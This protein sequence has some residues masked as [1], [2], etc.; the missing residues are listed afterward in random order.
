VLG[1]WEGS[2]L[3]QLLTSLLL[4]GGFGVRIGDLRQ[5]RYSTGTWALLPLL[6]LEDR[7][8]FAALGRRPQKSGSESAMCAVPT[9]LVPVS[10]SR[11]SPS[12]SCFGPAC[13]VRVPSCGPA[14]TFRPSWYGWNLEFSSTRSR[15]SCESPNELSVRCCRCRL[16]SVMC[17]VCSGCSG[18]EIRL[19]VR[20][21][22]VD[23]EGREVGTWSVSP[24]RNER[25]ETCVQ[26]CAVDS[27]GPIRWWPW[28]HMPLNRLHA[29]AD[30]LADVDPPSRGR[31][32]RG[33]LTLVPGWRTWTA[34]GLFSAIRFRRSLLRGSSSR[35]VFFSANKA[36]QKK[37][38][39]CVYTSISKSFKT[40]IQ[41]LASQSPT[42]TCA[43]TAGRPRVSS[44]DLVSGPIVT[45]SSVEHVGSSSS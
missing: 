33:C 39:F 16:M 44:L 42:L 22:R 21:G 12:G 13:S 28:W 29:N 5:L 19:R 27:S 41:S 24:S 8:A 15:A 10:V 32:R 2:G 4:L 25:A 30:A 17:A 11:A 45:F 40:L 9:T 38:I 14:S 31:G 18:H 1:C 34:L 6:L 23:K 7:S 43:V 37:R 35:L 36:N 3:L 26:V 20:R